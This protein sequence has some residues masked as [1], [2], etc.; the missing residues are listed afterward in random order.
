MMNTLSAQEQQ[1]LE[2]IQTHFSVRL[3]AISEAY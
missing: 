2:L 3:K 1:L